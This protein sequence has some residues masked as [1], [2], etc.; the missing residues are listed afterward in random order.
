MI[1]SSSEKNKNGSVEDNESTSFEDIT[2]DI[3]VND[4]TNNNNKGEIRTFKMWKV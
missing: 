3:N 4:C 1:N 2:A